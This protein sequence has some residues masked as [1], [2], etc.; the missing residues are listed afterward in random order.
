MGI[1]RTSVEGGL[2]K[3]GVVVG[4]MDASYSQKDKI[5]KKGCREKM[6]KVVVKDSHKT[7]PARLDL[8]VNDIGVGAIVK[9]VITDKLAVVIDCGDSFIVCSYKT[10]SNE[11]EPTCHPQDYLLEIIENNKD[12]LVLTKGYDYDLIA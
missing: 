6:Q 10:P 5:W 11:N 9:N 2:V 7:L 4:K 8:I 3:N 1:V 12:W